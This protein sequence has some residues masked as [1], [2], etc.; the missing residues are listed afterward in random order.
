M[1]LTYVHASRIF[2]SPTLSIFGISF[3]VSILTLPLY[4]MADKHQRLEREIQKRMKPET[5]NIKAV[6][7]GNER[8]MRLAAFYRQN[9]YN[10][11]YSLRSGFSLLIQI[12]FFIAA[13]HFLSTLEIIKGVSFGPIKDLAMPDSLLSKDN[14]SINILPIVM[15]AIN[16]VSTLIYAKGF[17]S[18][19]K[20]QLYGMAA[21]FLLL[22]YNSPSGLVLYWTGNNIFSLVKNIIGKTRQPKQ[23]TLAIVAVFSL[24]FV[25]YLLFSTPIWA[26][27][28]IALFVLIALVA[29]FSSLLLVLSRKNI[30]IFSLKQNQNYEHYTVIFILSQAVLFLLGGLLI[31]SSIIAS[32]VQEFSFIENFK[33]P[34]PFMATTILQSIGIFLLWPLSIYFMLSKNTQRTMAYI[35]AALS[36]AAMVNAFLFSGQYGSLTILFT[37]SENIVPDLSSVVLNLLILAATVTLVICFVSRFRR[38]FTS[39]MMIAFSALILTSAINVIK[40]YTEF[41]SYQLQ[42]SSDNILTDKPVYQFTRDGKNVLIMMIDRAISG[43]IPYIFEEKPELLDSYDGFTWYKNTVSFGP[44]TNYGVPG[45]FG[46]YEYTPLE[47]QARNDTPLVEKHNEA[48]LL[49]PHIFLDNGFDVTVTD[50]PLANY[51]RTPDLDIF[52]GYPQIHAENVMEKYSNKWLSGREDEIKLVNLTGFIELIFIRFSLFKLTP[53]A[54]RNYVYEDGKWLSIGANKYL[55]FSKKTL[56]NYAA[57]DVLP[58]ITKI[59]D[60]NINTYNVLANELTHDP[61]FL[62]APDYIPA[63]KVT[64]RGNGPFANNRDYHVNIAALLLIGK[65]LDF[66]KENGA[67]DNTRIIIVSDHG[68]NHYT[69]FPGNITLPNGNCLEFY[70]AFLLTKDFNDHGVLSV[71]ET[72]MTNA[73]VPLMALKDIVENPVNPWTGKILSSDKDDGIT[74]TTSPIFDIYRHHKYTFAIKPDEWMHIHTNIYEPDNWSLVRK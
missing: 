7:F 49:L 60:N 64:N 55:Y 62:Q 8:F 57:L 56:E 10:P 1:E 31:P 9:D 33:T 38:I 36:C 28:H 43:Y 66:L 70:A 23:I 21:I 65:W 25:I 44:S 14:F 67:Y 34:F 24:L 47:M 39:A 17:S 20:I 5:D 3:A 22:L 29:L 13:Y 27:K 6:F 2:H 12:P 11:L 51:K 42:M 18:K 45:I 68:I 52:S 54:L 4:F 40:I 30:K 58:D 69:K 74:L 72:F 41:N 46:G 63:G 37:F 35:S 15:T 32:S 73:D 26:K 71:N 61:W 50:P 16:C 48:L 19:E 59:N 53:L